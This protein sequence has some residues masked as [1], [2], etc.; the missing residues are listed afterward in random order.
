ML[1]YSIKEAVLRF[2]PRW[3]HLFF[4]EPRP[5]LRG[6]PAFLLSHF[7]RAISGLVAPRA[8]SGLVAPRAI[9]WLGLGPWYSSQRFSREMTMLVEMLAK[10]TKALIYL[11]NIAPVTP[12]IEHLLPGAG[13]KIREYN[14]VL[15]SIAAK[16]GVSL[17]DIYSQIDK[18]N[19]DEFVADG[20][21][22]TARGHELLAEL[23][24]SHL[25]NDLPAFSVGD[26]A[27]CYK[28]SRA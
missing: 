17:I 7:N 3:L 14:Q 5:L 10:E 28:G 21:H 12:R 16:T 2:W 25:L 18:N 4:N 9:R 1:H 24:A 22:L 8:I 6:L 13:S 19:L 20:I 27:I 15:A 26:G 11:I 23:L